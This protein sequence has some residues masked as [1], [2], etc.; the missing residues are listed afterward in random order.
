MKINAFK[1]RMFNLSDLKGLIRENSADEGKYDPFFEKYP[2]YRDSAITY[3]NSEEL[4]NDLYN[5]FGEG[6][7]F[8]NPSLYPELNNDKRKHYN[9]IVKSARN[10][11]P[12]SDREMIIGQPDVSMDNTV[13]QTNT[14]TVPKTTIAKTAVDYLY[15]FFISYGGG[16]IT[17]ADSDYISEINNI[18]TIIGEKY[19]KKI[20]QFNER[21]FN[22]DPNIKVGD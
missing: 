10:Y 15:E 17:N 19:G 14:P 7:P 5:F 21:K 20:S 6:G 16:N 9:K 1:D 2:Q 18:T 12:K 4:R 3:Q 11:T 8:P 13:V 22:L